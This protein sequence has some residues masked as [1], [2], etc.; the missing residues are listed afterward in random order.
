MK[1]DIKTFFYYNRWKFILVTFLIASVIFSFRQC[2][3]RIETDLG[4]LYI[5]ETQ[6][7]NA[8]AFRKAV[9]D[10]GKVRD[11]DGE[12]GIN[13]VLKEIYIPEDTSVMHQ[14]RIPEQIKVELISGEAGLFLID[15]ETVYENQALEVFYDLGPMAEKFGIAEE[16]RYVDENGTVCAI[17]VSGNRFLASGGAPGESMYLAI[18]N[19]DSGQK[20]I[21]MNNA[22]SIAEHIL[23]NQ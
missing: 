11:Y 23:Q 12:D 21:R 15:G 2:S 20:D 16:R 17:D 22:L 8:S 14:Q 19:H 6:T 5:S 3:S 18:K 9:L 4:I 10:T 1:T 13:I 7:A